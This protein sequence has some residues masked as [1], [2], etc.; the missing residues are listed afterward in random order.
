MKVT[1]QQQINELTSIKALLYSA[2]NTACTAHEKPTIPASEQGNFSYYA[3]HIFANLCSGDSPTPQTYTITATSNDT[4]MGSVSGGGTYSVGSTVTL[5][6]TPNNGYK[7]VS[8]TKDGAQKSTS[9]TYTFTAGANT[10]GGYVANFALKTWT[11]TA[12]SN[13]TNMGTVAPASST[14]NNGGSVT[15]TAT[16]VDNNVY[17]FLGWKKG[18][19]GTYVSTSPTY[20]V[21]NI[22]ANASYTGVFAQRV[23]SFK[24]NISGGG[25]VSYKVGTGT[26]KTVVSGM[27]Y[28]VPKD[29]DVLL[30]ETPNSGCNFTGWSGDV[31]STDTSV[32]FTVEEGSTRNITAT[33][34]AVAPETVTVLY[35]QCTPEEACGNR[36]AFTPTMLRDNGTLH[37]ISMFLDARVSDYKTRE[38]VDMSLFYNTDAF[39]NAIIFL[40]PKGYEIYKAFWIDGVGADNPLTFAPA[41]QGGG[42][43]G[44]LFPKGAG[45]TEDYYTYKN[46]EY[47]VYIGC[48]GGDVLGVK[49]QLRKTN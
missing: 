45:E 8:W 23:G 22:T 6:A 31:T 26:T 4:A 21:S 19:S 15:L 24:V 12:V 1:I 20:T 10:A 43:Y 27:S 11:V 49:Y 14:V 37:K 34:T 25:S 44:Y 5:T 3:T 16:V 35:H 42:E 30:T 40:I 28:D 47:S 9:A 7:F 13:D 38:I 36:L 17:K 18:T 33:F 46:N 2:I 48:F 32:R 41:E 39:T 29:S